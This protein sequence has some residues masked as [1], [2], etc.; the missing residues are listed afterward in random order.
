M[1]LVW[2]LANL[3][4]LG[5]PAVVCVAVA[6]EGV[7]MAVALALG[8]QIFGVQWGTGTP[9]LRSRWGAVH[10]RFARIPLGGDVRAASSRPQHHRLARW[11]ITL[12]PLLFQLF[13]ALAVRSSGEGSIA[14]LAD[15]FAPWTVLQIANW[16]LLAIHVLVPFETRSGQTSD[17]RLASHLALSDA[18]TDRA[19]RAIALV[20]RIERR[21]EL[22]QVEAAERELTQALARLG[23]EPML[24][25]LE[26][27]LVR[28]RRAADPESAAKLDATPDPFD[29]PS[30]AWDRGAQPHS[31]LSRLMIGILRL[32]PAAIAAALFIAYQYDALLAA[33]HDEWI[34][35]ARAISVSHDA[36][37]CEDHLTTFQDRVSTMTLISSVPRERQ[38]REL[39]AR[40]TLHA[41]TGNF[42]RAIR[43]QSLAVQI[44]ESLRERRARDTEACS[45]EQVE[46]E[47]IHSSQLRQ[48]AAW[49]SARGAF[50]DALQATHRAGQE[51]EVANRRATATAPSPLREWALETLARERQELER[52]RRRIIDGMGVRS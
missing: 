15:G 11:G 43:D 30:S 42:E 24:K 39:R 26:D 25:Q 4:L 22:G 33:A 10:H 8:F 6:R 2:P 34:D 31:R 27:R 16:S 48:L 1:D 28:I 5:L 44:A 20:M 13:S 40:A 9:F 21:L 35:E 41:C 17:L 37:S 19:G 38:I 50:R 46:A 23:R 14:A 36:Q 3:L 51:L 12:S 32:A 18:D 45:P 49:Y 47:L 29:H 52:T 7:R